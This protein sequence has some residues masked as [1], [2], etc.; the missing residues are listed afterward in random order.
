[1]AII[2]YLVLSCAPA[3]NWLICQLRKSHPA[4][5]NPSEVLKIMRFL[6]SNEVHGRDSLSISMINIWDT[7]IVIPLCLIY[8]KC[9]A[10]RKFP[11]I[12]KVNVL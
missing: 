8:E 10:A 12:W 9:L 2:A 4:L 3:L 7:E 5:T 6:D 1:M 11:E